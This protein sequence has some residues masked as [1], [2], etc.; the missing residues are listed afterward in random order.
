MVGGGGEGYSGEFSK[1][2]F[3]SCLRMEVLM[4]ADP[5]GGEAKGLTNPLPEQPAP[6][7]WEL[8]DV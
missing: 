7:T 6:N 1:F 3:L 2:F 4:S 8:I 5:Q